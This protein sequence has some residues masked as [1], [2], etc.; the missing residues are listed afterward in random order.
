MNASRR[1]RLWDLIVEHAS[2]APVA[3]EHVCSAAVLATGVD[4]AAV[5]VVLSVSPRETL[6]ASDEAASELE[7]LALTLG[8]GPGVDAA[9]GSPVL[10]ADLASPACL[11]RWPMYARAATNAGACAVF[12]LPLRVG[13][14]HLGVLSLYRATPGD[15]GAE[16][17]ADALVLADTACALLLDATEPDPPRVDRRRPEPAGLHHP[18]IHQATGMIAVQLGVTAAVA[19]ARL[20]AYA[21]THDRRL[22]DVA[23]DVV[24]RSLRFRP[25]RSQ[26]GDDR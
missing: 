3:V 7:E 14:I 10:V 6:C 8:E 21:Y 25:D 17:L 15:L 4:H 24:A 16:Q 19:L 23:R 12:A 1:M 13:A 26:A 20:R 5:T 18:E 9:V 2:G 22:R 11:I